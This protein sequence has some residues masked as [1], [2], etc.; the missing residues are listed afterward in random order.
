[1]S[2]Q[3]FLCFQVR[4]RAR[5]LGT[6]VG[7]QDSAQRGCEGGDIAVGRA[8]PWGCGVRRLGGSRASKEPF[9]LR[10]LRFNLRA[11]GV[12]ARFMQSW[13]GN[14]S[15]NLPSDSLS[16]QGHLRCTA[17]TLQVTIQFLHSSLG[18]FVLNSYLWLCWV[19]V[20][21]WVCIAG[22][23]LLIAAASLVAE[24]C[25]RVPGLQES[26]FPGS[27]AQARALWHMGLV[28]LQLVGSSPI[29]G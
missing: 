21:C 29:R 6:E 18:V 4:G 19:F 1:M 13:S 8:T 22:H 25:S 16:T 7:P 20:L 17:A 2:G 12:L 14:E 10:R 5:Q 26:W 28:A 24:P 23:R 15:L 3:C 11:G 9:T 27:R